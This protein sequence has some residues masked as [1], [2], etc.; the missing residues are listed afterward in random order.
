LIYSVSFRLHRRQLESFRQKRWQ[1]LRQLGRGCIVRI[2]PASPP[3][4]RLIMPFVEGAAGFSDAAS[5]AGS[6]CPNEANELMIIT[7]TPPITRVIFQFSRLLSDDLAD[8]TARKSDRFRRI[9]A[10]NNDAWLF[11]FVTTPFRAHFRRCSP[12]ADYN[13]PQVDNLPH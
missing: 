3:N 6:D 8:E 11:C 7:P 2:R 10:Q 12:Q 9:C 1:H 5:N 4:D 13:R